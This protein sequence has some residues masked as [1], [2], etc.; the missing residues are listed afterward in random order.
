[1]TAGP[2]QDHTVLSISPDT[3]EVDVDQAGNSPLLNRDNNS[4][5]S[6]HLTTSQYHGSESITGPLEDEE[7]EVGHPTLYTKPT[8]FTERFYGKQNDLLNVSLG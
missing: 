1:M 5:V 6:G 2:S 4:P 8:S 3:A 7:D